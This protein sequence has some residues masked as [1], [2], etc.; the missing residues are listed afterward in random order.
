MF[1]PCCSCLSQTHS[2][3]TC[4]LINYNPNKS[5]VIQRL[6]YS[7]PQERVF[8]N[9]IKTR[10][11][12]NYKKIKVNAFR[13]RF[14]PSLMKTFE[15]SIDHF[16][17]SD[18]NKEIPKRP[19]RIKNTRT[20][21][22]SDSLQSYRDII[23]PKN[24][25]NVIKKERN[26]VSLEN[27]EILNENSAA[28]VGDRKFSEGDLSIPKNLDEK[29]KKTKS[30]KDF[31]SSCNLQEVVMQEIE[32]NPV[33]SYDKLLLDEFLFEDPKSLINLNKISYENFPKSKEKLQ[34]TEDIMCSIGRGKS[35]DKLQLNSFNSPRDPEERS[36][37]RKT[38][39][40]KKSSVESKHK[41]SFHKEIDDTSLESKKFKARSRRKVS[42]L[43]KIS[44]EFEEH[45]GHEHKKQQ[46]SKNMESIQRIKSRNFST[47]IDIK[48]E[49][50]NQIDFKSK[51]LFDYDFDL[52]R[53]FKNYFVDSN[54]ENIQYKRSRLKIMDFRGYSPIS[55]PCHSGFKRRPAISVAKI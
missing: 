27:F 1:S 9:R 54:F 20:I 30:S 49:L 13:I 15:K 38:M 52:M 18:I 7:K 51:G 55:S 24:I 17:K 34:K 33:R 32:E 14:N 21:I 6:T 37:K 29:I 46:T 5:I 19:N 31:I 36:Y 50:E 28:L 40:P 12:V 41:F 47:K 44:K 2:I 4:P 45:F 11:L 26:C 25:K 23:K 16:Q 39:T 8:F 48:K 10:N 35:E 42:T 53:N 22:R 3:Y 43:Q